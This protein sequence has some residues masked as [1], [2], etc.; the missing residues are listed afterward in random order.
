MRSPILFLMT[1][2]FSLAC[3]LCQ[4]QAQSAPQQVSAADTTFTKVEYESH[5][6]GGTGAWMQ[7]L[8]Q[9]FKY[10]KKAVRKNIQGKVVVQFI[11]GRDGTVSDIKAISGPEELQQ[12]A[13]DIIKQSPPWTPAYQNGRPVKSYKRQPFDFRLDQ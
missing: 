8:N 12:A 6:P 1:F 7:F 3:H 13:V 4:A 5:F 9:H 11:V 2:L 10:P